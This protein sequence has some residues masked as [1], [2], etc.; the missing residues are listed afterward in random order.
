MKLPAFGRLVVN[1]IFL[2]NE[3][4]FCFRSP[5][6]QLGMVNKHF[7]EKELNALT[8]RPGL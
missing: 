2:S 8:A 4:S 3:P 1:Q 6:V 7:V 5:G